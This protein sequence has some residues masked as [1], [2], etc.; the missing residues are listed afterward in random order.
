MGRKN[1]EGEIE[2]DR[3]TDTHTEGGRRGERGQERRKRYK[4]YSNKKF[5][6]KHTCV[7]T[8]THAYLYVPS[9]TKDNHTN[10]LKWAIDSYKEFPTPTFT[11]RT[12]QDSNGSGHAPMHS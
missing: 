10:A 3:R 6:Y 8:H 2:R 9:V 7:H 11:K 12:T 5:V 1:W 4:M